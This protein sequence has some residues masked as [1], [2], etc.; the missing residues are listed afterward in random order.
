MLLRPLVASLFA[1]FSLAV[2]A[3]QPASEWKIVNGA[4]FRGEPVEALGPLMLFRTGSTSSKF[5]PMRGFTA[6]D[7]VRFHQ[8]VAA[9]PPRAARWS[10]AKGEASAECIGRLQRSERG[11]L[12]AFDFAAVPEPELL[13]VLY[14]GRRQPDS[15]SPTY[16]L[17]NLAPFLNRVQR[18]YPGR[19]A[20]VVWASRQAN[21]NFRSLPNARSWLVAEPDKSFAMK[22]LGGFAPAEGFIMV[23]MTREGIPLLGAPANDV[24]EVKKFVDGASDML[25]RLNPANPASARDRLHYLR[26]VRPVEFADGKSDAQLLIE[27]LRAGALRERGVKRIEAKFQ[28]GADGAV[29]AMELGAGSEIPPA[30]AAPL[31]EALRRGSIFLPAIAQGAAVP[32][33]Y[34][35]TLQIDQADPKL[36]ADAAWVNG[37]ARID[38]PIKSWLVLKPVH[39]PEQVFSTIGRVA[40][41]GTVMLNAV[42][43]G[44]A[45]K[46][47]TASQMNSFNS[48]WFA[49]AGAASVQPN[50]GDKQDVDGDKLAWKRL[51][52]EDGLVDFLEGKDPGSLDFCV[53]Y[54]WTE[55][56]APDD[57]DAW[58]G[59]G[60]DDGLKIW[61]NGEQ[62][63]DKWV[64]RTSRLDDDV[65]P[66]RLK[67]G[68]NQILI[69]IQNVKGRWS[70]I[71]RLRTRAG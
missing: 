43:A 35:Y 15:A 69:K 61:L 21:L 25:W 5:L 16:L 58:L 67:K 6:E 4:G 32:S 40:S 29:A 45:G 1:G 28:V 20:T 56:E 10:D 7:C 70:F 47:S 59:I 42:T 18:V 24:T 48:D 31:R 13:I 14:G 41:D 12:E 8:A 52:P 60:S 68:K 30:L 63:N 34:D 55:V 71:A 37:D 50:V 27:P 65:V 49:E 44:T 53:G 19:V 54:A 3:A 9:R 22:R 26:A 33:T 36:A 17:D 39:V 2:H 64:A 23:L 51:K 62:V 38:L 46:V 11:K 66:L 57:M